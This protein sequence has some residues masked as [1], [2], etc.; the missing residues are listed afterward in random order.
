MTRSMRMVCVGL[1]SV[2]GFAASSLP[3]RADEK[4]EK[5]VHQA[6]DK[7]RDAIRRHG[8]D[9]KEARKR[10]EQLED[11]RRRCPDYHEHHDDMERH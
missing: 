10:R 4:C 11:A 1:L 6:E 9:S 8:E 3:A 2:A 7:L 5:R